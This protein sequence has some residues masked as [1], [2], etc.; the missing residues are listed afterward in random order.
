MSDLVLSRMEGSVGRLTLNRPEQRNAMSPDMM[1]LLDAK[2]RAMDADAA[3]R[4]IVLDGAGEHFIAG[5]DIKAWGR[6]ADLSSDERG[7]DFRE[8]LDA[9]FPVIETLD[10]LSKPLIVAVRGY[11]VGAGICLVLAADFVIATETTKLL[12]ANIRAALNPDMGVTYWLPRLVG[13]R[14]AYRLALLGSEIGAAEAR[15]VGLVDEVVAPE[16][17]EQAV[18]AL[19]ERIC[20]APARAAAETRRLI[21]RSRGNSIA[22]QFSAEVDGVAACAGEADF[23]EAVAAFAERRPPRFGK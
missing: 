1:R 13:E 2:L 8:R 11:A 5:G 6:L 3:I 17:L 12:F 7:R 15:A 10:S 19:T 20:A 9:A 14:M 21:R 22:R 18:A 4:C 23:L 16:A